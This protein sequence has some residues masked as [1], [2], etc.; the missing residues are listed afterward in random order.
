MFE[1]I[2]AIDVRFSKWVRMDHGKSPW[3]NL[4]TFFAHSGDSW[5]WLAGLILAAVFYSP[6]R[7]LAFFIIFA[8]LGLAAVVLLIKFTVRRS[9]PEGKWGAIYRNTDPHSF[10]SGHAA[11]ASML[12]VIT[13][14]IGPVWAAV[15][16]VLWAALVSLSRVM[17]GMHYLSDILAG[18]LLGIVAGQFAVL[19]RPLLMALLPAVF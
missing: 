13:V 19:I 1:K 12:A 10:P 3:W 7:R 6:W 8:I 11:R 9:R 15:G 14:L 2:D 16:M 5:F 17:T 4:V 18:I